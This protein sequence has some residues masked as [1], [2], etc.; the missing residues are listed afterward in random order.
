M[1]A[2]GVQLP[3]TGAVSTGFWSA[4]Q[5]RPR[6]HNSSEAAERAED[7]SRL[8]QVA[9]EAL[10]GW[11]VETV[12]ADDILATKKGPQAK[13]ASLHKL[14]VAVAGEREQVGTLATCIL[15]HHS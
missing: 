1:Q 2:G 6:Q 4:L 11:L 3:A 9:V 13:E 5:D 8:L 14:L 7:L 12:G 15:S 10:L